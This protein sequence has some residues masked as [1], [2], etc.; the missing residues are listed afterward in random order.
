MHA[1]ISSS[2]YFLRLSHSLHD[3]RVWLYSAG[4]R[5]HMEHIFVHAFLSWRR[6]FACFALTA[7]QPKMSSA[8]PKIFRRWKGKN[9]H[10]LHEILC[11]F[12]NLRAHRIPAIHPIV[13]CFAGASFF[14]WQHT[15]DVGRSGCDA[16]DT[17]ANLQ[18]YCYYYK[19]ATQPNGV[20]VPL[21]RANNCDSTRHGPPYGRI[22]PSA[23]HSVYLSSRHR[24]AARNCNR[25]RSEEKLMPF[26][27]WMSRSPS[28]ILSSVR[29]YVAPPSCNRHSSFRCCMVPERTC[30]RVEP[31]HTH[32][33]GHTHATTMRALVCLVCS[34]TALLTVHCGVW[35]CAI[36]LY[37]SSHPRPYESFAGES[38]EHCA[39]VWACVHARRYCFSLAQLH[40]CDPS[41]PTSPVR[42]YFQFVLRRFT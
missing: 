17:K 21:Y 23:H 25:W 12:Q 40:A 34:R 4:T 15:S 11:V 22:A 29:E 30:D 32:T 16:H 35:L 39:H 26:Y 13:K 36:M 28:L 33:Q 9:G 19:V 7:T 27:R 3:C 20:I 42:F 38:C 31:C 8:W 6:L 10:F 5:G 41:P 24:V 37:C 2:P 18:F 14:K 1:R